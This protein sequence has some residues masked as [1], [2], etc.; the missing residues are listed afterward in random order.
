MTSLFKRRLHNY[1][2]NPKRGGRRFNSGRKPQLTPLGDDDSGD[3]DLTTTEVFFVDGRVIIPFEAA[4]TKEL[5]VKRDILLPLLREIGL[6]PQTVPYS[7]NIGDPGF[8]PRRRYKN[9][10]R[11]TLQ[12]IYALIAGTPGITLADIADIYRSPQSQWTEHDFKAAKH[13]AYQA[14]YKLRWQGDIHCAI[15][16]QG[17]LGFF[18]GPATSD[19]S[20]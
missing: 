16:E 19:E 4:D 14:T 2:R 10:D 20:Y 8:I 5:R 6:S 17:Q 3:L 12:Q 15:N 7:P 13:K 11:V 18:D 9:H 1:T